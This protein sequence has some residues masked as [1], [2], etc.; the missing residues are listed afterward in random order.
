[1][2]KL[3]EIELEILRAAVDKAEERQKKKKN[4]PEVNSI[5]EMVEDFLRKKQL[6]CYGGTAINNILP[7][8][9]QFYNRDL[10]IPDYDFF[11]PN[12]L[13]DAKELADIYSNKF[14]NVEAKSGV[15]F[16]TYKVFVNHIPVA[17]ITYMN[18][19]LFQA[20]KK[21]SIS[22]GG[23]LYSPPNYLRM[24]A[25]LELSRPDGD[26]S[27]WEKVLK[28]LILLNKHYPLQG[29]DCFNVDF[30][31][32]FEIENKDKEAI[33]FKIVKDTLINQGVVFFGA[34]AHGI[35]STYMP[36]K[37]GRKVIQNNPDF[38]VLSL[39]PEYTA[40]VVKERLEYNGFNNIN[41]SKK[42]GIGEIIA[43][44]YEVS[45]GDETIVFIYEP[46]ACH[47]YNVVK[48]DNK[49]IK[50]A[51]IDTML[52]FYLAFLYSNRE[53]YDPNRILCMSEFLFKVQQ[54][55]RLKQKGVLRR[56]SISCYGNQATLEDM[57]EEK[58][59]KYN[60]LMNKKSSTE[61]EEWFLRY[62][63]SEIKTKATKPKTTKPKTTKPKTTKP[64]KTK[65]KTTKPKTTKKSKAPKLKTKDKTTKKNK[66]S[67]FKIPLY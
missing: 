62:V 44:H 14:D 37:I 59:K 66:N 52:S 33:I 23:I 67:I 11:S 41:I 19:E 13:K 27:R 12:A 3:E 51:T 2:G 40:T 9:D 61:Y 65:S 48:I 28:R 4:G 58:S 47:S 54:R 36:K 22:V 46:L 31:R 39:K 25:Y 43:P 55:N 56:F 42:P 6:I 49:K 15:H 29:V 26:T 57:R 60:E 45:M 8:E 24:A 16:G 64:K 17:D 34:L 1:M 50:V 18:K 5:I 63:P 20:I 35:Y 32:G 53:Y 21:D 38:D 30:Q 7:E 10:E